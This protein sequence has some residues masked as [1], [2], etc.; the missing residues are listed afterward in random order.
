[1]LKGNDIVDNV[2]QVTNATTIAPRMYKLDPVI[3]APRDKN[4]K[5]TY[6]YNLKHTMKQAAILREIVEQDKLL[7]PLDSSSYTACKYVKLIQELL[8]YVRDTCPDIHKP[9]VKPSTSASG[10]QPSGNTKNDR[11][12]QPPSNNENN[13]VEFQS[14][15]VKSSLKKKN[16][17]SKNVCNEHVK[18]SVKGRTFTLV[19]NACPLTRITTT[20][21]VPIT[22]PIPLEV[23][24]QEPVVT[25]D[26]TRRPK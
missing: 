14:R 12:S 8:A 23:V 9:R 13:K 17:V 24:A 25:K 4:N 26:Y 3:L 10:S 21:K 22:E 20:N 16:Y 7:N 15:K 5:E 18:H 6:I 19:G 1:K 11:I 2:A